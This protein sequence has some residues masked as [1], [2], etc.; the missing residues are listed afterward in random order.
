[1]L[2]SLFGCVS[3]AKIVEVFAEYLKKIN[4][5]FTKLVSSLMQLSITSLEINR[6]KTG[7]SLLPW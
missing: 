3:T 5:I 4:L 2:S 6:L 1:M 7:N